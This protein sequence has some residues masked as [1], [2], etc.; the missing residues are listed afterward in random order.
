MRKLISFSAV[1]SLFL[2]V[3][4]S[5][6]RAQSVSI[7]GV[8]YQNNTAKIPFTVPEGKI[9]V[10][11]PD[12]VGVGGQINGTVMM[13]PTGKNEKQ[14]KENLDLLKQYVVTIGDAVLDADILKF[15]PSADPGNV[16]GNFNLPDKW[17]G[18]AHNVAPVSLS[19]MKEP[20]AKAEIPLMPFFTQ[21][22]PWPTDGRPIEDL[23]FNLVLQKKVITSGENIV[24]QGYNVEVVPSWWL[25]NLA[26]WYINDSKIT[27]VC[28]SPR[29]TVIAVP[30]A[31][32]GK[33]SIT[34]KDKNGKTVFQ[35]EV[36]VVNIKA[37]I[38]KTNLR[39]NERTTMHVT[40]DGV[41][42]CPYPVSM[43][44][45]NNSS[46]T[47]LLDKGVHQTYHHVPHSPFEFV[48]DDVTVPSLEVH[49]GVTGVVPGAF[50]ITAN[51]VLPTMAFG[52]VFHQ[53]K[54]ALKSPE[55]YNAWADAV[56]KDLK[57]Y[58]DKQGND[59]VGKAAKDNAQRAIDN[60]PKCYDKNKLDECKAFADAYLRPV[61]IP[62]GAATMWVCGFEAY[63]AAIKAITG[64][65]GGKPELIDWEVIKNGLEFIR[66]MGEQMKDEGLQNGASDA[67]K[68][69]EAI[70]KAGET[71]EKLQDFQEK[72]EEL[73]EEMRGKTSLDQSIL[74]AYKNEDLLISSFINDI[75]AYRTLDGTMAGL[76]INGQPAAGI[77]SLGRAIGN[78]EGIIGIASISKELSEWVNSY[79]SSKPSA[80][81]LGISVP[82]NPG[83][84]IK[85]LDF[86]DALIQE[87][88]F[89][90]M[91]AKDKSP[92]LL[93]FKFLPETVT[94]KSDSTKKTPDS[95]QSKKWLPCNFNLELGNLPCDNV[96][97]I[98]NFKIKQ[99][100]G[101]LQTGN[102]KLIKPEY[103]IP[104]RIEWPNI[105]FYVPE[106]DIKTWMDWLN[107]F[108][109]NNEIKNGGINYINEKGEILFS[110]PLNNIIPVEITPAENNLHKVTIASMTPAKGDVSGKN[111]EVMSAERTAGPDPVNDLIGIFNP[112]SKTLFYNPQY[113]QQ[114]FSKI[115]P[116]KRPDGKY[117]V[118]V[119]TAG[120]KPMRTSINIISLPPA[121]LFDQSVQFDEK[122]NETLCGGQDTKAQDKRDWNPAERI[123]EKWDST[124]TGYR[125]YKNAKCER[126]KEGGEV[127]CYEQT[128]IYPDPLSGS[129]KTRKTGKF[130][131]MVYSPLSHCF[132]G[133]EFCTEMYFVDLLIYIYDDAN[134]K[135]LIDV[136]KYYAWSCE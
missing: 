102:E 132:K 89:P 4:A 66:N 75:P 58:A 26:A 36:Y 98:E 42:E 32:I 81:N 115:Q 124:G 101:A 88:D 103:R 122:M 108:E 21:P 136:K 43:V 55:D 109:K 44:I 67:K 73:N 86:K 56:K 5:I 128:E 131:K 29:Q 120:R 10:Y 79:L 91:D 22:E 62:K 11:L 130:A 15:N 111:E 35:D 99:R 121:A 34:A 28:S 41:K 83:T 105:T 65:L 104:G 37:T 125:F 78:Y 45:V 123:G 117:D 61:N 16:S 46:E 92:L 3:P 85:T 74:Y 113:Q 100:I 30:P 77:Y 126:F 118:N 2:L 68:M 94:Y 7:T 23:S 135:R 25:L 84:E 8:V 119:L 20:V 72:L 13:E 49:Q 114:V 51:L 106:V 96:T 133:T 9:S 53:Q 17:W 134:C 27:P 60:I 52:D 59:E 19:K 107:N 80:K 14:K 112:F 87:I 33:T 116:S 64:T 40:A 71:K 97:K 110:V 127:P 69:V 50:N 54:S 47:V 129:V 38:D 18:I 24:L 39:K 90:K 6:T 95:K 48:K 31:T 93:T 57:A 76:N 82:S 12:D 63:K 70:Q 1:L